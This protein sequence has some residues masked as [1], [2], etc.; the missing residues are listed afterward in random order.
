ME[1]LT[2]LYS[3]IGKCSVYG[4]PVSKGGPNVIFP[5]FP[6]QLQHGGVGFFIRGRG[7]AY[8]QSKRDTFID[9]RE[10]RSNDFRFFLQNR[11]ISS[12]SITSIS[13]SKL[14]RGGR[15]KSP[16]S[17]HFSFSS[18]REKPLLSVQSAFLPFSQGYPQSRPETEVIYDLL[19]LHLMMSLLENALIR[20]A[21]RDPGPT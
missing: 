11:R 3:G 12:L 14:F 7:G 18:L 2:F 4:I 15:K 21:V 16:S 5:L 8:S 10:A 19:R 6:I 9:L 13:S 17:L 1:K 20:F